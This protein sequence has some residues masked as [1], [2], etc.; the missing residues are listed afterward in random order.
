MIKRWLVRLLITAA[1]FWPIYNIRS[2]TLGEECLLSDS[3]QLEKG[4]EH[5]VG[6]SVFVPIHMASQGYWQSQDERGPL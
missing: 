6:I 2:I 5:L 4:Y 3:V 1:R